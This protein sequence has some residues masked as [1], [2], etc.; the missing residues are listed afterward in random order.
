MTK[1][2]RRAASAAFIAAFL[3]IGVTSAQAIQCSGARPSDTHGHWWSWRLI[4]AR[5][6]WY[7]GKPLISKALLRWPEQ[8]SAKPQPKSDAGRKA[9]L[10]EQTS[11]PLDAQAS[12]PDADSFEARWRARAISD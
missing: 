9:V 2:F 11:D 1:R 10:P 6:C 5:K 4:D 12:V 3:S 7:E 8:A